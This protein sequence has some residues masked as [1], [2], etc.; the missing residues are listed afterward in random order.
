MCVAEREISCRYLSF[1]HPELFEP[2][3]LRTDAALRNLK[4]K[5]TE[6]GS[7]GSETVVF[8][9]T[10]SLSFAEFLTP[11]TELGSLSFNQTLLSNSGLGAQLYCEKV[12]G[13][14]P[15]QGVLTT[16]YTSGEFWTDN[17]WCLS[18]II[19]ALNV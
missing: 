18:I 12:T 6:H 2:W 19:M 11:L 1:T 16:C 15:S 7:P 8:S 3:L 13:S 5:L 10:F 14:N 9:S 4:R 17:Q